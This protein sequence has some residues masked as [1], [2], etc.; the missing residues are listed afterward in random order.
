MDELIQTDSFPGKISHSVISPFGHVQQSADPASATCYIW[1]HS[2]RLP[3][4]DEWTVHDCN[5]Y[6]RL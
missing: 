1:Q 3:H 2:W 6:R 4:D 5:W